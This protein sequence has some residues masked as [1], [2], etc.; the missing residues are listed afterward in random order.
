MFWGIWRMT[1]LPSD[2][3]CRTMLPGGGMLTMVGPWEFCWYWDATGLYWCCDNIWGGEV[4]TD[5]GKGGGCIWGRPMWIF[6]PPP[7]TWDGVTW[8]LWGAV[9]VTE[10]GPI[11]RF[12]VATV[13]WEGGMWRVWLPWLGCIGTNIF[14]TLL[15]YWIRFDTAGGL[16]WTWPS[17]SAIGTCGP[18]MTWLTWMGNNVKNVKILY[19]CLFLDV[20][21][22]KL[23][24]GHVIHFEL[25]SCTSRWGRRVTH[26]LP[27]PFSNLLFWLWV[28]KD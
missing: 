17:C 9:P 3:L 5:D 8:K 22:Q 14:G 21:L 25:T 2:I 16:C 12:W 11:R 19:S 4:C 23:P 20:K 6:W 7:V 10:G 28:D 18:L 26:I 27:L 1:S 15:T 24:R 13:P